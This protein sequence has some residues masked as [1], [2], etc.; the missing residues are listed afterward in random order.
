MPTA[1]ATQPNQRILAIAV[2]MIISNIAA[3]LLGLVDTAIIGHLPDAIY[4]SAVALGATAVSFLVFLTVFLRMTTTAEM[5]AAF[6]AEDWRQ[7]QQVTVHSL[8]LAVL[9]GVLL[10]LLSPWLINLSI[11]LMSASGRLAELTASYME[12]RLLALPATLVNLV[13]L[14]ILL[15][16]Q[17]SRP[18]MLLVI[19]LNLFN[20]IGNLILIVGLK[21]NVQGAAWASVMAEVSTALI[22][23]YLI[24][25][26]LPTLTAWRIETD[27]MKRFIGMNADVMVRSLLLQVCLA[28]MT[29]YAT[30]MGTVVVAANAVLMQFLLLISLGLDGIAYAVEALVGAARGQQSKPAVRFWIR[31]GMIWSVLFATAYSAIFLI[32]GSAIVALLTNIPTVIQQAEQ[33]LPW[34]WVMPLVA[35]WSYF[36]DGVYIGLGQ[37]KAMRNTMAISALG[38]FIP[39]W[40]ITQQLFTY[41][42]ANHGLWLALLLFMAAR[43]LSQALWLRYKII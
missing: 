11:E 36:Y 7:Q 24:R 2:P 40:W 32:F 39:T 38:V 4:L 6:G 10:A 28:M 13:V 29:V 1:I 9:L 23:L 31:H 5:A 20:V 17:Q 18:A 12:I 26:L 34:L 22:G 27:T 33:F 16:R 42:N 21:L 3:P 30:R 19:C 43:G 37:T 15:G 8:L 14:G 25:S 41:D 35:H